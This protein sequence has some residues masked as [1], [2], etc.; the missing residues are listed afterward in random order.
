MNVQDSVALVTGGNRGLGKAFVQAL[1]DAGA[2]KIYVG[3]RHATATSDSRLQ[4]IQLDITNPSDIANAVATCQDLTLLIN[5]AGVASGSLFTAPTI[6]GAR[7]EIETNYL[8][9]LA[10]SRAFAPILGRNGG[11]ALVNMLSV[12]SW[13]TYPPLASYSASKAAE[14]ALT[15]GIRIELRSQGTLVVGVHA[16][17]I[18]TEMAANFD[19][20]KSRPE[21]IAQQTIEAILAGKEEVLAD[22]RSQQAKA[23]LTADPQAFYRQIE[24]NWNK[25]SQHS[26]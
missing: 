22:Q 9:T 3:S 1:L 19:G 17:F 21:D 6:D 15:N 24:A 13:Y 4:P 10:I 14:L 20:P 8:G 23:A 2:R 11:G 5:N 18:D 7:E 26:K 25:I 12:L 16:G